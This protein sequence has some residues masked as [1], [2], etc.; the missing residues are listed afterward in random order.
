MFYML[1]GLSGASENVFEREKLRE[2]IDK[3]EDFRKA[4]IEAVNE[5]MS[6]F[7]GRKEWVKKSINRLVDVSYVGLN[8]KL[9][10]TYRI[11]KNPRFGDVGRRKKYYVVTVGPGYWCTCYYGK[12]G[13]FRKKAMCTHVGAVILYRKIE[14][15]FKSPPKIFGSVYME[16]GET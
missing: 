3:N 8:K 16:F 7:G 9:Q 6:T 2:A 1:R 11:E 13:K 15:K 10:H 14:Q 5:F 12:Y 4:Y